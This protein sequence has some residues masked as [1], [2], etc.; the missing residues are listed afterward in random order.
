MVIHPGNQ[1]RAVIEAYSVQVADDPFV[2]AWAVEDIEAAVLEERENVSH[3]KQS[4]AYSINNT[5]PHDCTDCNCKQTGRA[6]INMINQSI[7]YTCQ[8]IGYV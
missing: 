4:H 1:V 5:A 7:N 8:Q 2:Y 6:D 3:L